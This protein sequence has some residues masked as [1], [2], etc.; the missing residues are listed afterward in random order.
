[1][2]ENIKIRN[3]EKK[4][5]LD[6]FE[7]EKQVYK[8]HYSNSPNV[9]NDVSDLF[10]KIYF[11]SIIENQNSIAMGIEYNNKIVAIILSE[12]KESGS[13]SIVKKRRYCYID[14]I[15]V[16]KDYRRKGYAK[17]LFNEL[18]KRVKELN[19]DDIELTVWPFNKDAI[20][21]YESIG[22]SV[23]NIKY[24][25]KSN[26]SINTEIVQFNTSQNTK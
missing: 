7:L 3:L 12:I 10:P 21:F 25:L 17:K 22:M 11:D 20:A 4:D 18:K 1:M 19:V 6:V 14:D 13:I 15:V 23:K 9:Y 16:E 24:E 26:T 8:I 5:Y 2:E